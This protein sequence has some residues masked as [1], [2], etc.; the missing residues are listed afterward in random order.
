MENEREDNGIKMTACQLPRQQKEG[1]KK[2]SHGFSH[3]D[4][5]NVIYDPKI[6]Y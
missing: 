5:F 4:M 3:P 6:H 1:I 2:I